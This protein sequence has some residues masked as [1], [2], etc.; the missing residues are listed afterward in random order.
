MSSFTAWF[1]TGRVRIS[2]IS[3]TSI[4]SIS[5]VVLMSQIE[6]PSLSPTDIDM[7]LSSPA[8]LA[9]LGGVADAF[10]QRGFVRLGD[11]PDL[12][13]APALD[14][15]QHLAHGLVQRILVGTDV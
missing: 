9:N 2:M 1:M 7:V 5:G 6:S 4:T 14:R 11:E 13:D 8:A 12:D 10:R 3:S 15:V